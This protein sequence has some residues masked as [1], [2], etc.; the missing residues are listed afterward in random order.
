MILCVVL[1]RRLWACYGLS[2]AEINSGSLVSRARG[3][4]QKTQ[5]GV[6]LFD[7]LGVLFPFVRMSLGP[8]ITGGQF[9][10]IEVE[11][12][13]DKQHHKEEEAPSSESTVREVSKTED[14]GLLES[15]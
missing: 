3:M 8:T 4:R 9:W 13:L 1:P 11:V 10:A 2:G 12:T 7:Q 6:A 14:G 5:G 15:N